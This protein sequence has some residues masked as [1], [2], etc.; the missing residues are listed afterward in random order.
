MDLKSLY[1]NIPNS[2][3]IV[4]LK[5]AY[6]NY[7]SKAIATKV[8]TTFLTLALTLNNCK[9]YLKIKGCAMGA[10]WAP[11]NVN[12]FMESFKSKYIYP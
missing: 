2:E 7:P 4:A 12:I 1:I 6:S 9:H 11:P 8:I 3:G 10:I 5:K